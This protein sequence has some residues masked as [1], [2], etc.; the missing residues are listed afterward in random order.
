[1]SCTV[2]WPTENV[3]CSA[4]NKGETM[5]SWLLNFHEVLGSLMKLRGNF[6]PSSAVLLKFDE[7]LRRFIKCF[8]IFAAF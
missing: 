8:Q 1:M 2:L 4:P 6:Y 3:T 5:T 7:V